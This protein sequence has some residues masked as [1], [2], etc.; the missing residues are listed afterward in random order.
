[1]NLTREPP[2]SITRI[3]C[4]DARLPVFFTLNSRPA[5]PDEH[6]Y[7]RY[8]AE[9]EKQTAPSFVLHPTPFCSQRTNRNRANQR[10]PILNNAFASCLRAEAANKSRRSLRRIPETARIEDAHPAPLAL[11]NALL[12]HMPEQ[13]VDGLAAEREHHPEPLLR[14]AQAA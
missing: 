11:N 5:L 12:L 2:T 10:G 14:D 9:V 7:S 8:S 6:N 1:M 4:R 13:F 3:V